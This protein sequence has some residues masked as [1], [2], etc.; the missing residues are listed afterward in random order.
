MIELSVV[1]PVLNEADNIKPL[2]QEICTAL[3]GRLAYEIVYVNDGSTDGTPQVLAELCRDRPNFR[4]LHHDTRSGQSAAIRSG[5]KAAHGP[6]IATLDGD[7]QNDPADI[8]ALWDKMQSLSGGAV[9]IA[10]WRTQRKD[11]WSKRIA[12]RIANR[13]RTALLRDGTPDTGCGLKLF[14]RDVFLEFPYFTHY[15]RYFAALMKRQGGTVVSVPVNHRP[16]GAGKSNY[17]NLDRALVG[18]ADLFGV[19]WLQRRG[20]IPRVREEA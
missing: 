3:E 4:A 8:P 6:W 9:M 15:H 17:G 20:S 18:I 5:V 14:P 11:V 2:V 10:G 7:G 16:R 13:I 19:A 1:V 12:S